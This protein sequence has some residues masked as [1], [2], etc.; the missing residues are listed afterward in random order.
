M[1]KD[2]ANSPALLK[3]KVRPPSTLKLAASAASD[4]YALTFAVML[5]LGV[6]AGAYVTLALEDLALWLALAVAGLQ[7]VVLAFAM[8]LRNRKAWDKQATIRAE[9]W[10]AQA[11]DERERRRR[12]EAYAAMGA[13]ALVSTHGLKVSEPLFNV[14]GAPLLPGGLVDI[15]GRAYGEPGVFTGVYDG[16]TADWHNPH[17]AWHS[18]HDTYHGSGGRWD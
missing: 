8:Y 7:Y 18:P 6:W 10:V 5:G 11:P 2:K 4:P 1:T 15:H 3:A 13:A 16:H 9:Q 17:D 14:D 12:R